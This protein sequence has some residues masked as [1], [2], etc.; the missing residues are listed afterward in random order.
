MAPN[1]MLW[2]IIKWGKQNGITSIDLWGALGPP[3]A[4][5]SNEKIR[6]M[7]FIGL[8]KAIIQNL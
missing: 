3:P 6:G 2:D 8:R 7:V 5:G 1:L 4:G